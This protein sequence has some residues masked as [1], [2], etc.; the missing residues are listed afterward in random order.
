MARGNQA[1][2][3][4]QVYRPTTTA[5]HYTLIMESDA[6]S[7]SGSGTMTVALDPPLV[8]EAGDYIGW[9]HNGQGTFNFQNSGGNVRWKYGIEAV[10]STI[11]FNGQGTFNFQNSGGNVRWK[12]GIEAV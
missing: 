12:Y 1:G 2:L 5:H 11:N 6:L 8:Y 7:T 3:K 4:F 10:G 9:V